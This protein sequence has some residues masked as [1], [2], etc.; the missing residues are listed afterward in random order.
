MQLILGMVRYNL[1][2]F[3]KNATQKKK[4]AKGNKRFTFKKKCKLL[5]WQKIY[6]T[7]NLKNHKLNQQVP[8]LHI[9]KHSVF[10]FV[11]M[12]RVQKGDILH[13]PTL[14]ILRKQTGTPFPKENSE[15]YIKTL[16]FKKIV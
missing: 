7:N 9:Y 8:F 3:L 6:L 16:K 5:K 15:I 2:K 14:V 4:G 12:A 13:S 10:C 1:C 11:L